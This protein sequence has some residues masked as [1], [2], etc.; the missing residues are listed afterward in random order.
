MGRWLRVFKLGVKLTIICLV[1]ALALGYTNY[2]T[3]GPIEEQTQIANDAARKS[4]LPSAETFEKVDLTKYD[5]TKYATVNEVY[6]GVKGSSAVGYTLNVTTK[7]Y[8]G[9]FNVTVGIGADGKVTGVSVGANSE[10]AGL[11]AN[12]TKASFRDQY[13]GKD[14]SKEITV[15]KNGTP[16]DD[17]INALS[18][19]T[20]TSK[21]VTSAVNTATSFFTANLNK[22]GTAQ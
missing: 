6:K 16:K 19:A 18:G 13:I 22:G 12:A 17:Q 7:G 21:A 1:A 15:I 14:T 20:I 11:G 5:M 2:I 10:T 4:T 3:V 9:S 8:G